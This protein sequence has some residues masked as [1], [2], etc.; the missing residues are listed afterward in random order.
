MWKARVYVREGIRV[1]RARA[2]AV[3]QR[4]MPTMYARGALSRAHRAAVKIQATWRMWQ[5]RLLLL[6]MR[7]DR[8]GL[9]RRLRQKDG[10]QQVRDGHLTQKPCGFA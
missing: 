5:C 1:R 3:L 9:I 6:F 7:A 8:E 4:S 10:M 2:V